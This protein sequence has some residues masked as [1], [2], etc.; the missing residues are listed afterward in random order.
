MRGPHESNGGTRIGSEPGMNGPGLSAKVFPFVNQALGVATLPSGFTFTRAS[1]AYVPTSAVSLLSSQLTANQPRLAQVAGST[2]R[3]LMIERAVTNQGP[4]RSWLG[5]QTGP[6]IQGQVWSHGVG[7]RFTANIGPGPDGNV[8]ASRMTTPSND[9]SSGYGILW[10]TGW[11]FNDYPRGNVPFVFSFYA[12]ADPIT[13]F[14]INMLNGIEVPTTLTNSWVRYPYANVSQ[15]SSGV[16][17][18]IP[19][20]RTTLVGYAA[21]I[22]LPQIE[23]LTLYPT[24]YA[25]SLTPRLGETLQYVPA[26]NV[27]PDGRLRI[28]ITFAPEYGSTQLGSPSDASQNR[29]LWKLGAA[30]YALLDG[31]RQQVVSCVGGV[32]AQFPVAVV[33]NPSSDTVRF[34][35]DS[36]NGIPIA[37]VSINGAGFTSLGTATGGPQPYLRTED[38]PMDIGCDSTGPLPINQLDATIG[39]ITFYVGS[40]KAPSGATFYASP[41]GS[42]SGL[43]RGSPASLASAIASASLVQGTVLLRGGIYR[44]TVPLALT[45]AQNGVTLQ[46]YPRETP[47]L[48]G[49]KVLSG[50]WTLDSGSVYKLTG[51]TSIGQ[52]VL[53]NGVRGTVA[54]SVIGAGDRPNWT[55]PPQPGVGPFTASATGAATLAAIA[56]PQDAWIEWVYPWRWGMI[57]ITSVDGITV[58]VNATALSNSQSA[59]GGGDDFPLDRSNLRNLRNAREWMAQANDY[60]WNPGTNTLYWQIPDAWTVSTAYSVGAQVTAGGNVYKALS[61]IGTSALAG[62]GPTGTTTVIDG[63]VTWAWQSAV[64]T[65]LVETGIV[66]DLLTVTGVLGTPATNLHFVGLT[67]EGS[68]WSSALANSPALVGY[69]DVQAGIT[70]QVGN[71]S[72]THGV[73]AQQQ[74]GVTLR[75]TSG[76]GFYGCTFRRFPA[77]ALKMAYANASSSVVGCTFDDIAGVAIYDG[78]EILAAAHESDSRALITG[79]TISDSYFTNQGVVFVSSSVILRGYT[80]G[81]TYIRNTINGSGWSP[82]QNG[83]GWGSQNPSPSTNSGGSTITQNAIYNGLVGIAILLNGGPDGAPIY[84]NGT[85]GSACTI[86][87]NYVEPTAICNKALYIDDGVTLTT[88]SG[89]VVGPGSIYGDY[90]GRGTWVNHL[91]YQGLWAV[92]NEGEIPPTGNL[93][94]GNYAPFNATFD[95]IQKPSNF[96]TVVANTTFTSGIVGPF[97]GASAA[98]QKAAGAPGYR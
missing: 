22:D 17:W 94:T 23:E 57:P 42:G 54:T 2:T 84:S 16:F 65:P 6:F 39:N 32:V 29:T 21:D 79:T 14:N 74:S 78:D 68:D 11:T 61:P 97:T 35:V 31:K 62:S 12:Q 53:I 75:A 9:P 24:T 77:A 48:S 41:T 80:I 60:Y 59:F 67:F 98:I 34:R 95:Y 52:Q 49:Q 92:I 4:S 82:I 51:V 96:N 89:N 25:D 3:G 38:A 26:A 90:N 18:G 7:G 58:N 10:N 93:V 27:A 47:I 73:Y 5:S 1:V 28:D 70:G 45:A 46:A 85:V 88:M 50:A 40:P 87:A 30:D 15:D 36:G 69:S 72:G 33:F 19:E 63:T 66:N 55:F 43:S 37:F 91:V 76:V 86:T 83:W 44:Q 8:L 71:Y 13:A 81:S 64:T 20:S 56:R